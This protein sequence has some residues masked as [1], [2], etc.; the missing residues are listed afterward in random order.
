MSYLLV[1]RASDD[2]IEMPR[3]FYSDSVAEKV[4]NGKQYSD[5]IW[6]HVTN[7]HGVNQLGEPVSL[8]DIRGKVIVLDFFFTHCP[9]I[10]PG[11]TRSMKRL[12]DMMK[13]SSR[14]NVT[15]TPMVHFISVSIDPER[16]SA[17]A[18][19]KYADHYG[20]NP[21]VWWLMS[22]DKKATYRFGINEMKLTVIDG[23][24]VDTLFDH[25]PRFVLLDRD[26]LVRGYYNG[27][28]SAAMYKLSQDIV[29][30]SLER[31]KRQP[32]LIVAQLKELWPIYIVVVLAVAAFAWM[33]WKSKQ[34]A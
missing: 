28:D 3:R 4:V 10:C 30:L 20:V 23:N 27:L 15:D 25:S 7:F 26:H 1:K 12:Q 32:S 22:G 21:D 17:A 24:G 11:M 31:D 2:A 6:H 13:S 18:L 19:K 9:S 34:S 5:T 29:Y 14:E 33:S 8:N 16:D